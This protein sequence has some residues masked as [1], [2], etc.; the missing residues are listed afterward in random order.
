MDLGT[1]KNKLKTKKY[2]SIFEVGQDVRLIWKNC[3]TYNQ[4]G[5]DFYKLADTLHKKWDEKYNKLLQDM[6][7]TN[8]PAAHAT[9]D[10]SSGAGGGSS[11]QIKDRQGFA[12]SLY[13]ISK[14]DLGKVLVELEHRCPASIVR[15]AQE[16]EIELNIDKISASLLAELQNFV[17]SCA[18]K[19]KKKKAASGKK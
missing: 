10:A 3:M 7:L 5:S 16:D 18:Q 17:N 8:N 15:N 19:S 9:A 13:G 1:V 4:D 2:K 14:E 6:A 11:S 12:R